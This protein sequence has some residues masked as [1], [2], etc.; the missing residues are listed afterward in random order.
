MYFI[1]GI[2]IAI[3]TFPGVII[4]ELAHQ[5]AC[6]LMKVPVFKVCYFTVKRPNGY[7]VHDKTKTFKQT[8]VISMGPFIVNTVI[9]LLLYIPGHF[10]VKTGFIECL[11]IWLGISIMMHAFPSQQDLKHV[12]AHLK[13]KKVNL[14]AKIIVFPITC[15]M[16]VGT[17]GSVV[18]LDLGYAVLIAKLVEI[19]I[20]SA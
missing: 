19:A 5:L 16:W 15:I 4:H 6:R 2:I 14:L 7:V 9:G 17:V 1:P 8:V 3:A 20:V 12:F 18:W 11:L 10:S 13:T